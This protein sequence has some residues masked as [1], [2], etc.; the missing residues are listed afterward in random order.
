MAA[1]GGMVLPEDYLAMMKNR[2]IAAKQL[3]N[4]SF[5]FG[6]SHIIQQIGGNR[7]GTQLS[8]AYQNLMMGRTTQGLRL[9]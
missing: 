7:A 9:N 1:S 5:Y 4:K 3:D 2:G 6:M 8:S